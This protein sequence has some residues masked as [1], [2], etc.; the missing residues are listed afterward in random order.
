[1]EIENVKV[2][3]K[4]ESWEDFKKRNK[5]DYDWIV[6][7]V[8]PAYPDKIAEDLCSVQP[9][10]CDIFNYKHEEPNV[11]Q[12]VQDC[13]IEE[14]AKTLPYFSHH[15]D[16]RYNVYSINIID[17]YNDNMEDNIIVDENKELIEKVN[18]YCLS[19]DLFCEYRVDRWHDFINGW[20]KRL[21]FEIKEKDE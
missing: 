11:P 12:W 19:K 14:F 8:K 16:D 15:Y 3:A 4:S 1:M 9:M 2:N 20:F 5:I 6:E 18:E 21:G 10:N 17:E 13:G 7:V